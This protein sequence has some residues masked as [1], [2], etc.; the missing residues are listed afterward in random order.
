MNKYIHVVF[1]VLNSLANKN[2]D[3]NNLLPIDKLLLI[4]LAKHKGKNGI[5]P[6]HE[7][8]AKEANITR[9][10]AIQRLL[11]L[12]ELG[13]I[14]I[15]RRNKTNHYFLNFLSKEEPKLSTGTPI[16]GEPQFTS[17]VNYSSPNRCTTVHPINNIYKENIVRERKERAPLT[18][19][20]SPNEKLI[21]LAEETAKKTNKTVD[22]LIKK[23]KN[24]QK[25][26]NGTSADWNAEFENFL[27]NE[28]PSNWF[29]AAPSNELK[30]TI[31]FFV[32]DDNHPTHPASHKKET[33]DDVESNIDAQNLNRLIPPEEF[34]A[35]LRLAKQGRL[36]EISR[37]REDGKNM[38]AN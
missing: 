4:I 13:I 19:F 7:T 31:P 32:F 36:D 14:S 5:F 24:L 17:H 25:S 10:Y 27:Y 20:W 2:S 9:R 18:D 23:F 28:R 33:T 15:N 12:E 26:K 1:Q 37:N 29:N 38:Q 21:V 30:C 6:K 16:M 8:I 11:Y 34:L 22:V 35:T 3:L